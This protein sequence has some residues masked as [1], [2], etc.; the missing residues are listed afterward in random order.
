MTYPQRIPGLKKYYNGLS[1]EVKH[2]FNDFDKLLDFNPE[3][4]LAYVFFRIEK[5]QRTTLYCAARKLHKAESTLT[6]AALNSHHMTR[7]EFKKLFEVI[8]GYKID[9]KILDLLDPSEKARDKLMHG[10]NVSQREL[11]GGI[12]HALQYAEEMN[13][14]INQKAGFKPFNSS[15]RGFV[16]RLQSLDKPT[17]RWILKGMGLSVA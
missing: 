4:V 5:G 11:V 9:G 12:A 17:T 8:F 1:N 16:G 7:S 10:A 13:A 2:Y 6:W 14:F 3:I 15:L